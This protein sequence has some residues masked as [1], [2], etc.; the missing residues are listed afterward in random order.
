[1]QL[2]NGWWSNQKVAQKERDNRDNCYS[3]ETAYVAHAFCQSF[4]DRFHNAVEDKSA[5]TVTMKD[6]S[7]F[8]RCCA[9]LLTFT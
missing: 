5:Q 2:S 3:S 7:L 1:M 8:S 6:F 9:L 4:N